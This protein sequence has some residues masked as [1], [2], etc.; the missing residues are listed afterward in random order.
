[1]NQEKFI[2][3]REF[4]YHLTDLNNV[5]TIL[6]TRTILSTNV[7]VD[8]N[9]IMTLDEKNLLKKTR[10]KNHIQ[11][12]YDNHTFKI[13]DQRPLSPVALSKCLTN[14]CTIEEYIELLNSRVFFWPTL[15][16]L[17]IHFGRYAHE[18]PVIIRCKTRDILETNQNAELCHL[19]SGATRPNAY[20]GGIASPRGKHTFIPIAAFEMGISKV[21]EV[22]FP[23]QCLLPETIWLSNTPNGPWSMA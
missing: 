22:T 13:R 19:N 16:R 4:L 23:T 12:Q 9:Q 1:M 15:K 3:K 18:K 10:R 17:N 11:L 5:Q 7:I 20:L 6:E 21:A 2:Q 8:Q 14:G